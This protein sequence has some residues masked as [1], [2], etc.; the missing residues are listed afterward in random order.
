M[1]QVVPQKVMISGAL[2]FGSGP[3]DIGQG[4]SGTKDVNM[5][6]HEKMINEK[7]Q[8][9]AEEDKSKKKDKD[10]WCFKCCSKGHS[11][12]ECITPIFCQIF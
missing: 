9:A 8:A 10:K 7:T 11:S 6:T 12:A 4:S 3:G 5:V 2:V 1:N